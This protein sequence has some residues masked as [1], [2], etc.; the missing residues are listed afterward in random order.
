MQPQKIT[1]VLLAGAMIFGG[2][3]PFAQP[4]QYDSAITANSAYTYYYDNQGGYTGR[5]YLKNGKWTFQGFYT[6]DGTE[7]TDDE[8]K[9]ITSYTILPEID[10]APVDSIGVM[11]FRNCEALVSVSIPDGITSIGKS[12]F[13]SCTSLASIDIPSSVTTIGS[14][15]FANCYGLTSVVI[16]DGV[17]QIEGSAFSS[18]FYLTSVTIPESVTTMGTRIFTGCSG[19]L[20]IYG[21]SSS[22]AESYASESGIP[23][24]VLGQSQEPTEATTTTT[25]T[26]EATT[27]TST[28]EATTTTS[29]TEAT[30]TTSTTEATTTTSTTEATTTTSTTEATTTTS[31]TEA[32]T[33]TSTTEATTTTSTTEATTTTTS[34]TETTTTTTPSTTETTVLNGDIDGDK[35]VNSSDASYILQYAAE[36]GAGYSGSIS[37]FMKYVI[38]QTIGEN[39]D[40]VGDIDGNGVVGASD[41]SYIL[42]YAAFKGAGFDGDM[43]EFM[44]Y[45]K[46]L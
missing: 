41:A 23:F 43:K 33:T 6:A 14:Y 32:T 37:E 39:A 35:T 1:A 25:S 2:G 27:T 22:K 34:T 9:A 21:Y 19:D 11:A 8:K 18:C 12:A 29:T 42:Q 46:I 28:T 38:N 26:T 40:S 4:I 44:E 17:T 5:Y 45:L 13:V 24:V 30:T 7:I 16:P 31:T 15:A 20:T 3:V 36:V 10:G